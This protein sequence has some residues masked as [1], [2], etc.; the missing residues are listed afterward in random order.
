MARILLADDEAATRDL[1]RRALTA[2]GHDVVTTEDGQ[3]ALDRLTGGTELFDL[4]LSDVQMPG[5]DGLSLVEKALA[6]RP[7][8]KV[9]LMSGHVHGIERAQ[10][11]QSK[12]KATITKPFTLDQIRA[13]VKNAL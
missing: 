7:A 12:I 10:A 13:V 6:A 9:V 8:L 2:D 1:V 5:L 3:E 4:L 11:L